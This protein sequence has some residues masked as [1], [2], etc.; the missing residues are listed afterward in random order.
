VGTRLGRVTINLILEPPK[1]SPRK[2][3]LGSSVLESVGHLHIGEILQDCTLHSQLVEVGVE[4]GD[5]SLRKRRRTIEVHG[6]E[7][8]EDFKWKVGK[9]FLDVWSG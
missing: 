4:E 6:C 9:G 5:D 8:V 1:S 2:F 7:L 3:L